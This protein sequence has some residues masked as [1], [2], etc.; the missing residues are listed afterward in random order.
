MRTRREE[1]NKHTNKNKKQIKIKDMHS[2]EYSILAVF[3]F[4]IQNNARL[5]RGVARELDGLLDEVLDLLLGTFITTR[6]RREKNK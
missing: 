3:S 4:V 6:T 1:K 2:L 5:A